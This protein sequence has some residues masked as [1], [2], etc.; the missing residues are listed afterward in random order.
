MSHELIC[1]WLQLPPESW[2]PNHYV[3]LGLPVGEAN[4]ELIEK[5]VH[6]RMLR[7]RAYQ[8]NHPDQATEAMNRLAQAFTCLT[9]PKAKQVYD[10]RLSGKRPLEPETP[11][12]PSRLPTLEPEPMTGPPPDP[13]DPLAWL[14]G[15]WNRLTAPE[16]APP[17]PPLSQV[18]WTK[19]PPPQRL[20]TVP[21]PQPEPPADANGV[22][23]GTPTLATAAPTGPPAPPDPIELEARTSAQARRGLGT[24]RAL[25]YRVARTR[26]LL[27]AWERAGRYLSRS[28][29][30]LAKGNEA[31]DLPRQLAII[32]RVLPLFPPLLGKAGQ[33]GY[34]VVAL[35]GLGDQMIVPTFRTLLPD[36][37]EA[38]ARDWHAGRKLLVAHRNFLRQELHSLRRKSYIGRMVR[39]VRAVLNEHPGTV[40]LLWSLVA[41]GLAVWFHFTLQNQ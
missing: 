39:A 32:R 5:Q 2:P 16:A 22:P 10:D 6:E 7:V 11:P 30:R 9:D 38:L 17:V 34:L 36:Q 18:D 15:P 24:K 41:L 1:N 33:P 29:R 19:A 31:A 20:P 27:W 25:Y 12:L 37:R 40:L 4:V 3:L 8:M 26:Q 14:F 23:T 28:T 13:A 21:P 35:A